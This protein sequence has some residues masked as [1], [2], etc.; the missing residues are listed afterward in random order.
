M[1]PVGTGHWGRAKL[2]IRIL[3][4][5][6][7]TQRKSDSE[8]TPITL[9]VKGKSLQAAPT[10]VSKATSLPRSPLA[11][12]SRCTPPSHPR[13]PVFPAGLN[14][15]PPRGSWRARS[16]CRCP[17]FPTLFPGAPQSSPSGRSPL[18][19]AVRGAL[20]WSMAVLQPHSPESGRTGPA[21]ACA[22]APPSGAAEGWGGVEVGG[23]LC[24]V[25]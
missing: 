9:L 7:L 12:T 4:N 20:V 24:G 5:A 25:S 22:R 11:R 6:S 16:G 2:Q 21:H 17:G 8:E 19:E 18:G 13:A 23:V 10:S 3:L 15:G 14:G 1:G